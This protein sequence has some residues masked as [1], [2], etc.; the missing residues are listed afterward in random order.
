MQ[1]S[2]P[3]FINMLVEKMERLAT[4]SYKAYQQTAYFKNRK[5][6]FKSNEILAVMNFAENYGFI[7]Q[8]EI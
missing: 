6:N 1:A 5:E 3:I 4:H 7:L 2:I 8:D